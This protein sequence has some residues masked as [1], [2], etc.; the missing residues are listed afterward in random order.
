MNI[1]WLTND[2]LTNDWLTNDWLLA[3][4]IVIGL[5]CVCYTH[6]AKLTT[7]M[8]YDFSD[9]HVNSYPYSHPQRGVALL[10]VLLLVVAITV[11]AGSMLAS[12]KMLLRQYELL[13]TQDQI[14]QD[15]RSGEQL[16]IA[17]I[18]ADAKV[19]DVDSRQ[20]AWANPNTPTLQGTH[21]ITLS[22]KDES[23][24]FNINNLYHDGARD[25]AAIAVLQRL[26]KQ[27]GLEANLAY[28]VLDWQD[29]DSQTSPEGGAEADVYSSNGAVAT[30]TKGPS[31]LSSIGNQ[32][33]ISVDE[34]MSVRGFS[35]DAVAKLRPFITAVPYYLPINL[36]TADS[37]VLAALTE[38]GTAQQFAA[39]SEQRKTTPIATVDEALT[40]PPWSTLP[41][42][43]LKAIKPL[44]GVESQAFGVLIDVSV[45]AEAGE[46]ATQGEALKHRYATSF[47]SKTAANASQTLPQAPNTATATPNSA[48]NASS[49]KDNDI[50]AFGTHLWSYRPVF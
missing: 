37:T 47:I 48:S 2:W 27:A 43:T 23:A 49:D 3:G 24:K 21:Q 26:L 30:N 6:A 36:N 31:T 16:A 20:D 38:T 14:L 7:Y 34:L 1:D 9:P 44:I 33:F 41:D 17:L 5:V 10:T 22:I 46:G 4:F 39:F 8:P 25:D 35:A 40:Q 13:L 42:K 15:V 45:P 12:Q 19:N 28:A 11:L 50:Q 29:P 18:A 32:A